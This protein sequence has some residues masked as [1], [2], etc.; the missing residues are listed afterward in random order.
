MIDER[1]VY[2]AATLVLFGDST[3][4]F[5]VIKGR[6]KPN[7]VTWFF[8]AFAPFIAFFAQISK[9]VGL[10]SLITFAY[11]AVPVFIFLAAF[12][13]K[14]AYW[15]LTSFDLMCGALALFGLILWQRTGEG[16]T[17]IFFAVLADGFGTFPTVVKAW[18]APQ[19]EDYWIYLFNLIAS[20]IVLLSLKQWSFAHYIFPVYILLLG[21]VLF[22]LIRF[23]IGRL[24][25]LI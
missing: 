23:K 3:Y 9:G 6:I 15:K 16:N 17:A 20:I 13:N 4:L 18:K 19:S 11:G 25:K 12:L 5:G 10:S 21:S 7:K 24:V 22:F 8:W 1:L 2:L 14:K